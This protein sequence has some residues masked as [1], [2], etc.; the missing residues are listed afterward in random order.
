MECAV[1][2]VLV[3]FA[4]LLAQVQYALYCG[5]LAPSGYGLIRQVAFLLVTVLG[6]TAAVGTEQIWPFFVMGGA[7]LLLP[8]TE[9]ITGSAYPLFFLTGILFF[10]L[11]SAHICLLRRRELYTQLSSISI[12]E[13]IDTLRTGLLFYRPEGDILLCKPPDG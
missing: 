1:L 4:A 8:M 6:T 2:A 11:R 9:E 3:L 5:F 7:A 10:L 13:A 12:K